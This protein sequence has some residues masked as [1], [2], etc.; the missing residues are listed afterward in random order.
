MSDGIE[1]MGTSLA[2][3]AGLDVSDIEE[4]RSSQLAAGLYVF[5][6]QTSEFGERMVNTKDGDEEKRFVATIPLKVVEVEAIVEKGV[7][8]SDVMGK[9]QTENFFINPAE[10]EKG[11]GYLKG[12]VTDI[13]CDS[14]G[15]IGGVEG[16][17]EGFL[18]RITGHRFRAKIVKK[19]GKDGEF[20]A[21]LQL[22]KPKR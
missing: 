2:D 5:E 7:E 3:I 12:F 9:T 8:D 21:R 19:K 20:Y 10:A 4:L 16:A 13:G 15:P 1:N 14:S 17:P 18:D 6:V 22:V 11:I